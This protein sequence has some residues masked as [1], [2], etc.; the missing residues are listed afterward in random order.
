MFGLIC[1]AQLLPV[2]QRDVSNDGQTS[3]HQVIGHAYAR[4]WPEL[5][6]RSV[7]SAV[8]RRTLGARFVLMNHR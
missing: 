3:P 4:A 2:N 1:W 5:R 6:V 7:I 8:I